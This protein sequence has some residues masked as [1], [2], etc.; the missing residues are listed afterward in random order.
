MDGGFFMRYF[1]GMQNRFKDSD[2]RLHVK[3]SNISKA[4]VCPYFGR[5]I[6]RWRD[7][8]LDPD[9]TYYL[10]RDPGELERAAPTFNNLPILSE[11]VPV[12]AESHRPDLV[13]GSSGTDSIFAEPYLSNSLVFWAGEYIDKIEQKEIT[14]LS[15]GYR[16]RADMSPGVFKGLQYDGIMRDI[17]GNHICLV[18]EGR[19][20]SDVVVGDSKLSKLKTVL[21]ARLA[22]GQ[23]LDEV[24]ALALDAAMEEIKAEDED[25]EAEEPKA[26]D[27]EDPDAPKAADEGEEP[28]DTKGAMDSAIATAVARVEAIH[29]ARAAVAPYIGQVPGKV[30]A[31][32]DLYK[33]ALDSAKVSTKGVHPSAWPALLALVPKPGQ[34]PETRRTTTSSL[35]LDAKVVD[36]FH[37]R[38]PNARNVR[39]L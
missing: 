22:P 1:W 4:N 26:A 24:V 33:M 36:D 12:S 19:T 28:Y 9:R 5:E 11:H 21:A 39:V 8:G 7:L 35:A 23:N 14:Q 15:P 29:E 18:R 16:Y 20:G 30:K 17:V 3:V 2:G 6:P 13:I 32:S 27:E 25:P 38:Y 37:S 10:L 34:E 31:A